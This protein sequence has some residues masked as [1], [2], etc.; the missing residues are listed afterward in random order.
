MQKFNKAVQML[1]RGYGDTISKS[2]DGRDAVAKRTGTYLQRLLEMVSPY[3]PP[4]RLSWEL[5]RLALNSRCKTRRCH[6]NS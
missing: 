1:T 4:H 6:N 2:V 5:T 3:P